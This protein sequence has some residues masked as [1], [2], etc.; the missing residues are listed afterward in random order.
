[1]ETC[2]GDR[3]AHPPIYNRSESNRMENSLV[4]GNLVH[5]DYKR[6]FVKVGSSVSIRKPVKFSVVEQADVTGVVNDVKEGSVTFTVD[7]FNSVPWSF[8]ST[9]LT[10]TID[11][12][13]ERYIKPAVIALANKVDY[14]LCGLYSEVFNAVGTAGTTPSTFANLGAA[15]QKMDEFAVPSDMRRMVLNPAA[16]WAIADANKGLFHEKRVEEMFG[17]GYL[18]TIAGFDIF[19]DQNV[20]L[21]TEGAAYD[22]SSALKVCRSQDVAAI[23]GS[24]TTTYSTSTAEGNTSTL[25]VDGFTADTAGSLAA[26]D[27][28]TIADVYAVNPVNK[29]STGSLQQFVVTTAVT[30][31]TKAASVT[32]SPPINITGPFQTVN[33]APVNNADITLVNAHRANLAFHKN[34]FGLVTVPLELPDG[35]AFKARESHN[36]LSIRIMKGHNILTDEETIRMDI[37]YGVKCIY[38]ELAVRLMG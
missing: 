28:I 27:I 24:G 8:S 25:Y 4:M 5:R 26:G 10:L 20:R 38:P 23:G 35:A 12:Y 37:L 21:H 16:N 31:G 13:S 11:Q 14:N 15:A 33:A 19:T 17:K 22:D 34:A 29:Q 3:N 7:K 18:N 9:D 6:E 32:V 30:P 2:R 1:M 36:G